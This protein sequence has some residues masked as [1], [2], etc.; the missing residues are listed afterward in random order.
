MRKRAQGLS[1]TVRLDAVLNARRR[2]TSPPVFTPDDH[3]L[4]DSNSY[5]ELWNSKAGDLLSA[6]SAV[7][8][9][10]S[11][12][13]LQHTGRFAARQVRAAL[14]ISPLDA[15]M[16]LGCGVGRIGR[17]LAPD[18]GEWL[19]V[20][21]SDNMIEHARTRMNHLA[22]ARF[23]QLSRTSLDMVGTGIIDKAYSLAVLFHMDKE[24]LY[25]YLQELHRVLGAGGMVFV[26]TWNLAHPVG[27]RRW[28]YEPRVW[29]GSDQSRRK[30]VGRNQFCTPDEFELYIRNAGFEILASYHDSQ[31]VQVVAAKDMAAE[32]LAAQQARLAGAQKEIA[33]SPLYAE[34]F[35]Q[36][37]DMLYGNLAPDIL[38]DSI[39][40]HA[41][42][43]EAK[44][45]RPYIL[46]LWE[47]H[48]DQ[49]GRIPERLR[50]RA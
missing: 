46:S 1:H 43:E 37:V 12:E 38:M 34:F 44:L 17:E 47:K 16:E 23:E 39:D 20:D 7:D 33:Y 5:K 30:D 25:L 3:P 31:C 49:W 22:N 19:G 41:S 6:T 36:F 11:E 4:M 40:R 27:W 50:P 13:V 14:D 45:Y 32:E 8:G 9:S 42:T 26:E 21:I 28:E 10:T 18:C 48:E 15:V 35:G 2:Y 24:D 29:S